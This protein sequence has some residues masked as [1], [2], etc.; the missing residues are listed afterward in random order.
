MHAFHNLKIGTRLALGFALVLALTA[1][2][3]VVAVGQLSRVTLSK[4]D[5][6]GAEKK[7]MLAQEWLQGI[8]TNAVRTFARARSTDPEDER[9]FTAEMAQVSK[10][11]NEVAAELNS[12]VES[13]HGKGLIA[14]VV[15]RRK[16][17]FAVRDAV[18]KLKES[19]GGANIADVK[20]LTDS[21]MVP[22]MHAY[23]DAIRAV[24]AFQ[25]TVYENANREI[26]AVADSARNVLIGLG[27]LAVALGALIAWLL[28]RSIIQPLSQA[29]RIARTVAAGDLT[30]SIQADSQ[31]ETGQLI[32]ALADMNAG[33][34]KTVSDVRAGTDTI[35]T[36]SQ[37]IAAGNLDLSSRTEQQAS[38]LQET[39][40][41]M[42]QLTA[43]VKQNA[44]HAQQADELVRVAS[45]VAARGGEVIGE[46]VTTMSEIN[47]SSRRVSDIITVIDG[48][49]FQTNILALNAAVEAARAGEQ[50]R[51]FAVV[52]SEVRTLAQRSAAAAK[53]IKALID[54][55]ANRVEAGG[56]LVSQAGST[57]HEIVTSVE[58]VTAIMGEIRSASTEQSA[59]IE[60]INQAIAQMDEATQQNASL[61]EQA[62]AASAA[63]EEQSV[64]LAHLVSVFKIPS[65]A[66]QGQHMRALP[67]AANDGIS[68]PGRRASGAPRLV[69]G[70]GASERGR[71]PMVAR[72][73]LEW[74]EF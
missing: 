21:R 47:T 51:G 74:E 17:Y 27:C 45:K 50:G 4:Q 62:A 15:E 1:L 30:A 33:L 35:A 58:K 26:D 46:V 23:L 43:T 69:A 12:L 49:A 5:M 53:E 6:L 63:M 19:G 16:E 60:Q 66:R 18:F 68:P 41:S 25:H 22:A 36:A 48:I 31:D 38:S 71:H 13:E 56:M 3:S 40:S 65:D 67:A 7:K 73:P 2:M 8:E 52:A 44:E 59:G 32:A 14:Q 70:A 64:K 72:N 37:Q 42:E 39:A 55:S 28:S 20:E 57:M 9:Y 24:L 34:L 10:R 11:I 61:V 29:V 54:A